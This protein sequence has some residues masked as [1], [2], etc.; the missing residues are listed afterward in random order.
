MSTSLAQ[1]FH[2]FVEFLGAG[3]GAG[4]V[5]LAPRQRPSLAVPQAVAWLATVPGA[6]PRLHDQQ[7]RDTNVAALLQPV[8]APNHP[9][10]LLLLNLNGHR[11]R[12]NGLRAPRAFLLKERDCFQLGDDV[13]F[14]VTTFTRPAVGPASA[15]HIGKECLVCRTRFSPESVVYTCPFCGRAMHCEAKGADGLECAR[16]SPECPACA[17]AVILREGFSYLPEFHHD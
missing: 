15:A 16:L 14:H 6:A 8:D 1:Q 2:L 4:A 12:V 3:D 13:A 9:A 11:A 17:R 10:R 7:P 5:P